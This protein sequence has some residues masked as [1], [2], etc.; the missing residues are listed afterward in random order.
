MLDHTPKEIVKREALVI[1]PAKTW[2]PIG[3]MYAAFGIHK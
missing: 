3:A 1:N 2:Q